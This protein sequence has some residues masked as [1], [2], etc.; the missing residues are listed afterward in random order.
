MTPDTAV[1]IEALGA[2]LGAVSL[3]ALAGWAFVAV[4]R[5][6]RTPHELRGDWWTAFERQFRAYADAVSDAADG[7]W[8]G[9]DPPPSG[10]A[11]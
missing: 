6:R 10:A 1:L 9:G 11:S 3:W 8:A 2:V 5:H 4:V 7:P